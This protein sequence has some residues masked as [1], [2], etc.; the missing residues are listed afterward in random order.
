MTGRIVRDP[1]VLDEG[2]VL[3]PVA[4]DG[5]GVVVVFI[6]VVATGALHDRTRTCIVGTEH[7]IDF[8]AFDACVAEGDFEVGHVAARGG[9]GV[10]GVEGIATISE[11]FPGAG[12]ELGES[13]CTCAG[14]DVGVPAGFLVDGGCDE[15]D[16]EAAD[17]GCLLEFGKVFLDGVA[18]VADA[19][20]GCCG[21]GGGV[22]VAVV[23]TVA[24]AGGAGVGACSAAD[25]EEE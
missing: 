11:G 8:I 20:D 1:Q 13:L 7:I 16:G 9:D 4:F 2:L 22:L 25:D 23:A 6:S 5:R 15:G 18:S 19:G 17:A 10:T 12:D 3:L 21:G 14:D 24:V